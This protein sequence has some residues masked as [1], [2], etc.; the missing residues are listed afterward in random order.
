MYQMVGPK[1]NSLNENIFTK[2]KLKIKLN[3]LNLSSVF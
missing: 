2:Y 1:G 3:L